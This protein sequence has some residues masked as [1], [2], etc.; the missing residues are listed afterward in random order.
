MRKLC[1]HFGECG[2][3]RFQD[4]PY[5][6]Q[7]KKKE[8]KIKGLMSKYGVEAD[9]KHANGFSEWFY[10]NKMEFSFGKNEDLVCGFHSR[11][12]KRQVLNVEECLIFSA[13]A[14]AILEAT[15]Q[16]SKEKKYEPYDKYDHTG[17]L[18]NLIIRETKFTNQLMVGI[19]TTADIEFDKEDF[20]NALKSLKL[21]KELKSIYHIKNDSWGDAVTFEGKELIFGDEFIQERLGPFLFN[22]GIE[23]FFQVNPPG[24]QALYSK[25]REYVG[26]TKE[27]N[28]LDLYCGVGTISSFLS[29][30]AKL[31]T[32]VDIGE[33]VIEAANENAKHN[34]VNNAKFFAQDTRK[35]LFENSESYQDI[36]LVVINP[37][38]SGL[39]GK[40]LRKV[41]RL[42][43]KKIA[44]S[45]CNPDS[46]IRDL[47]A[48]SEHYSLDFIEP[49]DF[50]PHTPHVEVLTIL[51]KKQETLS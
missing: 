34:K 35:F 46:C 3:C 6:D 45:S 23:T 42:N 7:L 47:K 44:Y 43:P 26:L 5:S 41:I 20:I 19:V 24:V 25:I 27:E 28:V 12:K 51:H 39:S 16:F 40:V 33:K 30:D 18:R 8:E 10:R 29:Q 17:Y 22:I 38:R 1:K 4:I 32:G 9:L 48:L 50:F 11:A 13:D 21:N 14:G 49:F 37:P 15:R 31:V 36:D 2:G